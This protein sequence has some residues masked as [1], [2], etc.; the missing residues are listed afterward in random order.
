MTDYVAIYAALATVAA[1]TSALQGSAALAAS[2]RIS[3]LEDEF[4]DT[5]PNTNER[6]RAESHAR[7]ERSGL[8]AVNLV[9]GLVSAAVLVA[10]GDVVFCRMATDWVFMVPWF[11]IAATFV[12]MS[13]I[14]IVMCWWR[15]SQVASGSRR[16][17]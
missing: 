9:A 12:V 8:V 17:A 6:Q 14:G 10:W 1:I 3:Q 7:R 13:G 11:A 2:S 4:D 5:N 16:S 15:V